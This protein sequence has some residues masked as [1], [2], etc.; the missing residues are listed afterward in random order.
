MQ[1]CRQ[2]LFGYFHHG[3]RL[4]YMQKNRIRFATD[5]KSSGFSI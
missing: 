2:P 3:M 5:C 1:I 4:S